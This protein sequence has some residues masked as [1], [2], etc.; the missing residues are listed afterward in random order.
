MAG[1][2][3]FKMD[4]IDGSCVEKGYEK[5]THVYQVQFGSHFDFDPRTALKVSDQMMRPTQLVCKLEDTAPEWFKAFRTG[6]ESSGEL[7]FPA[8]DGAS[9]DAAKMSIKFENVMISGFTIQNHPKQEYRGFKSTFGQ[10]EQ[11][12][13]D[14]GKTA[15]DSWQ[16]DQPSG[17]GGQPKKGG[18]PEHTGPVC[19]IELLPRKITLK[20]LAYTDLAKFKHR[21][22]QDICDLGDPTG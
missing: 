6:T 16:G 8:L 3:Y 11:T 4:K 18:K 17:K 13:K 7:R 5:F 2:C 20:H 15:D 10:I 21:S 12:W 9:K 1:L 14:G 22:T 19:I